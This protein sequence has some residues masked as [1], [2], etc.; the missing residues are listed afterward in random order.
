MSPLPPE[1]LK[2]MQK[3]YIESFTDLI[4]EMKNALADSQWKEIEEHF[5]RFAGSGTTYGMPQVTKFS[6]AIEHYLINHPHP[7]KHVMSEGLHIFEKMIEGYR[8]ESP[9]NEGVLDLFLQKLT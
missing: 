1:V 9:L 3:E 5:H 7:P 2:E 4:K 6:R 8:N